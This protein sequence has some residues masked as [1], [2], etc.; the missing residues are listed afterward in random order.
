MNRGV[1]SI[2]N[3]LLSKGTAFA[4]IILFISTSFILSIEVTIADNQCPTSYGLS[5]FKQINITFESCNYTLYGEIYYP[6][7][8]TEIYPGIV[9]CEGM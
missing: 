1:Y 2:K 5:S 8:D 7:N 3:Y 4:V 6:S 9:F